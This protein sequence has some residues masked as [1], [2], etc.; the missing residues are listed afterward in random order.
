MLGLASLDVDLL[1]ALQ[2]GVILGLLVKTI[3]PEK[4]KEYKFPPLNKVA[5]VFQAAEHIHKSASLLSFLFFLSSFFL[6]LFE[7]SDF[8]FFLFFFFLI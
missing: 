5:N 6:F 4:L 8:F 1:S 7:R 2:N 3:S